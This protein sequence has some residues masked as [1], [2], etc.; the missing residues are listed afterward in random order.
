[1]RVL[2]VYH[3]D[4]LKQGPFVKQFCFAING[5]LYPT[6]SISSIT[7]FQGTENVLYKSIFCN[8]SHLIDNNLKPSI[9]ILLLILLSLPPNNPH[10]YLELE[11]AEAH[12][13]ITIGCTPQDNHI[14]IAIG[15]TIYDQFNFLL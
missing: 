10:L 8:S 5:L 11:L 4:G 15:C 1:M 14:T 2:V 13:I 7:R 9:W 12:I 6:I 3:L